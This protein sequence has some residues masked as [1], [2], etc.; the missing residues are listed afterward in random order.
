MK[1]NRKTTKHALFSSVVSLVLCVVMLTGT[2]YAWF[3]DSVTSANN[4]IQ[5]GTL[6]VEMEYWDGAKYTPVTETT[7]LFD[8]T[9]VWEPGHTEVVYL[10]I[11]NIGS[12]A[13]K[14]QLNVNVLKEDVG[15]SVN[16]GALRLSDYLV[17]GVVEKELTA[18]TD[19]YTRDEA[20]AA[21]GNVKGLESYKGEYTPLAQNGDADYVALVVYM[22]TDVGNDANHDGT[23]IPSIELGV[24]VLATQ[25]TAESDSFDSLYDAT[26][27]Y[28][29]H[30]VHTNEEL[31]TAIAE[32]KAGDII[33]LYEGNYTLPKNDDWNNGTRLVDNLT[34]VGVEEAVKVTPVVKSQEVGEQG[35]IFANGYTFENLTF[36]N[37]V[38]PS[39]YGKFVDCTFEGYNGLRHGA[40]KGDTQFIGCVFN[41]A[42]GWAFHTEYLYGADVFFDN[43]RFN[44]LVEFTD[45]IA[46]TNN[47]YFNNCVFAGSNRTSSGKI[48]YAWKNNATLTD[49][50]GYDATLF[51]G[52]TATGTATYV[53]AGDTT[54]LKGALATENATVLLGA[55][56]YGACPKVAAGTVVKGVDGTVFENADGDALPRALSGATFE[57]V[58]IKGKNAVSWGSV[59]TDDVVFT[60]CTIDTGFHI[61]SSADGKKIT[62]NDCTF[63]ANAFIKFGGSAEYILNNCNVE[64]I[65]PTLTAP[66]GREYLITY[67]DITLVNCNTDRLVRAGATINIVLDTCTYKGETVVDDSVVYKQNGT[68]F[69]NPVVTIR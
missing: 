65:S 7:K 52:C 33:A 41:N 36:T 23:N 38:S 11:S 24:S 27:F 58:T 1:T 17:F 3:T 22:P 31:A 44:G 19:E 39:G 29:D 50:A 40:Y 62:F 25:M 2:T 51:A 20:I 49:C 13:L 54:A 43:C 26:A 21:A 66:W 63:T 45:T 16:G 4:V 6:N 55:G 56:N 68:N 64:A 60:N 47:V 8:E 35:R 59:Q 57:N 18:T 9:A 10:K 42:D 37:T 69:N 32:A 30:Y 34:F 14:Y 15:K 53:V 28:A 67:G 46:E 5:S 61:D 12:L 48:F